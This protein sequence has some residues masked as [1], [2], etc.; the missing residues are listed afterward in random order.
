MMFSL[1]SL[2]E[3]KCA[4]FRSFVIQHRLNLL[5]FLTQTLTCDA[6]KF[7]RPDE[8]HD[9]NDDIEE[10]GRVRSMCHIHT[11]RFSF[12]ITYDKDKEQLISRKC[13][14]ILILVE[15][16]NKKRFLI[17]RKTRKFRDMEKNVSG[18]LL[19]TLQCFSVLIDNLK[20]RSSPRAICWSIN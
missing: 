3:L 12:A 20:L 8:F 7:Q 2:M 14:L 11:S 10:E 16:Q 15:E 19:M 18:A 9:N 6:K 4:T 5:M 13:F 17:A 1:C